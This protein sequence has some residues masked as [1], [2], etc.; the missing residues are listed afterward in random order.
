MMI[1]KEEE[2][3][4]VTRHDENSKELLGLWCLSTL[5]VANGIRHNTTFLVN[6][7]VKGARRHQTPPFECIPTLRQE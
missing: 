5:A 6:S 1:C 2:Q 7:Q 3:E 4:R